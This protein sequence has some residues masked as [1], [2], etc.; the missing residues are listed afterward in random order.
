MRNSKVNINTFFTRCRPCRHCC[1]RKV[2]NNAIEPWS[3]HGRLRLG[4][5]AKKELGRY[6]VILTSHLVNNPYLLSSPLLLFRFRGEPL[7]ALTIHQIFLL[8]AIGLNASRDRIF[9]SENWR[10]SENIPQF[11]K[12]RALR[13][14]FEG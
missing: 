14:R 13:K 1:M 7:S 4:R 5:H 11:S 2:P 12:L 6:P 9:P 8:F 10:I 3:S